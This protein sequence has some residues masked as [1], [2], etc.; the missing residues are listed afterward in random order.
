MY[1]K[2]TGRRTFPSSRKIKQSKGEEIANSVSHGTGL[3]AALIGTSFLIF[4]A[5]RHG[6]AEIVVCA[7][8]F[9]AS[10]IFLYLA[11]TLYHA[12]PEGKAKRHFRIIEH[13]AIFIL[14]A[15]TYTPLSLGVL[16]GTFGWTLFGVIWSL[17][18][19]GVLLKVFYQAAYPTASTVLYLLMGWLIVIAVKPLFAGIPTAGM[20]LLILGGLSYTIG[21]A[22]F[23]TDSRLRYGHMIWHLF[24]LAGTTCH[25]FLV[26]LYAT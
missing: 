12:L 14:I 19:A 18:V 11:S 4:N 24:V 22:F 20:L 2:G 16:R 23:V 21:V 5:V 26:L 17:A 7:S 3:I 25:Y 1:L 9:S 15:G 8:V 13:A 6:S 10:M